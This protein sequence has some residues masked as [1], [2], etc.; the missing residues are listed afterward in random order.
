MG[1]SKLISKVIDL[2]KK[3]NPRGDN[4]IKRITP[5]HMAGI[6]L[7]E[8]CARMHL[9][10]GKNQSASAY[11]GYLGDAC[12]GVPEERRP[13]TSA[14]RSNDYSAYTIEVSND[15]GAPDWHIPDVAYETL[16][17][18]CADVCE[19]YGIDPHYDGTPNGTITLHKMFENTDCPGPYLEEIIKSGKFEAD[20]KEA[21][22]QE[23][24]PIPAKTL[25]RVQVGA[26]KVLENVKNMEE[27]LK[28]AGYDTYTVKVGEL[29]KIQTGAFANKKNAE[30]LLKKLAD[31][32]FEAFITQEDAEAVREGTD[33]VDPVE[34]EG[35]WIGNE[36]AVL[37]KLLNVRKGAGINHPTVG[38]V[39][40]GEKYIISDAVKIGNEVWCK[41]PDGWICAIGKYKYVG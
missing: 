28:D 18:L 2:T 10:N 9:N 27:R 1:Y 17:K 23:V 33:K 25:Y 31:D 15:G 5:H 12:G 35:Y 29:Y 21:M 8:D 38:T 26:F 16:V 37:V 40:Q 3:S 13:W 32:G 30:K 19:R 11:V 41:I 34:K 7:A 14:S 39:K 4:V 36:Y 24:K 6:M 20:I 22:G